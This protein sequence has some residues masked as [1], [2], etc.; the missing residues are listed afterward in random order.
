MNKSITKK[1]K[2]YIIYHDNTVRD[3]TALF[4]KNGR[5]AGKLLTIKSMSDHSRDFK[6]YK[7]SISEEEVITSK[8]EIDLYQLED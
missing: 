3:I 6:K 1:Q 4:T 7:C 8:W 5:Q 2:I